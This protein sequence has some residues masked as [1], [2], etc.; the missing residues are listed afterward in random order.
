MDSFAP[1]Q[2]AL[3]LAI[4]VVAGVIRGITGFGGAMVMSPPFAMLLGAKLTVPVVLLLEG[5]AAIPMLAGTHKLVRW[6][7]IGPISAA[8]FVA[9]PLGTWLLLAAE[10]Q[11][12]RRLIAAMVV[13]F[14]LLLLVGWRYAGRQRTA[15]GV[16]LGA[17]SGAMAGATS[18][19]GPPVILYLLAGPDPVETTRANLMFFICAVSVAG[20]G[21]LA[22]AGGFDPRALWI[23]AALTPGYYGGML[24]GA[25]LFS[26]FNDLRFRRLTLALMLLVSTG[27][28]LA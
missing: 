24:L 25:R 15:T 11:V 21:M 16:G 19:G 6:N 7:V 18:I 1:E 22:L 14:S 4:G 28:L 8:A 10:P 13:V 17:L 3:A 2:I 26:R 9:A 20:L 5:I 23:A 27:I 12:L